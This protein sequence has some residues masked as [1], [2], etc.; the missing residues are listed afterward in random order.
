MYRNI[1]YIFAIVLLAFIVAAC[2]SEKSI[3]KGDKYAAVMEY[4][5]AAKEYKKAYRKIPPKERAKRAEVAWKMGECYRHINYT[6][7]ALAA[8]QNAVRYKIQDSTA[9]FQLAR[10]Q[11]KAGQY[12]Q[13]ADNF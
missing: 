4:H 13:A 3:R 10:L 6:Q 9:L 8:Y 11:L 5:E 12:K 7:K 1:N 2:S